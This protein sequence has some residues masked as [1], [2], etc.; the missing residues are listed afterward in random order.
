MSQPGAKKFERKPAVK[1][2]M[3]Q[4]RNF[5]EMESNYEENQVSAKFEDTTNEKMTKNG[6]NTEDKTIFQPPLS[7]KVA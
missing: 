1:K 4:I 7:H 6:S 2:T 5:D 3:I